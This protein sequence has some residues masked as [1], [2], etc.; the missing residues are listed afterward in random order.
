[1][2]VLFFARDAG[3]QETL[4]AVFPLREEET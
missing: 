1:M 2:Y 3:R 4:I